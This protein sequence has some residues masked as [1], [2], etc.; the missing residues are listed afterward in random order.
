MPDDTIDTVQ[1]LAGNRAAGFVA[2]VREAAC[3]AKER[4]ERAE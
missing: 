2:A 3:I 1:Q 4:I